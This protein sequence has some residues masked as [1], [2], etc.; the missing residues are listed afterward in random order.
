MKKLILIS[1]ML[2]SL[3]FANNGE[4][5]LEDRVENQLK[6]NLSKILDYNVDYDVDIFQDKMNVEIEIEGLKEPIIDCDKVSQIILSS[7][8]EN[9]PESKDINITIKYD[10]PIGEDEILFNKR[11]N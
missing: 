8:K 4:D 11:F 2:S 5:I 7:I 1:L 6:V 9:A 3:S 10:K